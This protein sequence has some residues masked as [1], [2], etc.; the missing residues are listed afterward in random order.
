MN[1]KRK[2]LVTMEG[3]LIQE[4]D[5]IPADV[6][7]VVRDYD[8]EGVEPD[9]LGKDGRGDLY[10]ETVWEADEPAEF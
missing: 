10:V 2:I 6:V 8:V 5:G 9:R 7:I 1:D 4:I 3:G